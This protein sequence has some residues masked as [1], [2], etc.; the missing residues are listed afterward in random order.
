MLTAL[1]RRD[2]FTRH[3]CRRRDRCRLGS[4]LYSGACRGRVNKFLRVDVGELRIVMMTEIRDAWNAKAKEALAWCPIY[5]SWREGFR[6][7]FG[8]AADT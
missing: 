1:L 4:L 5:P 2:R 3:S 8:T 6:K 7:G